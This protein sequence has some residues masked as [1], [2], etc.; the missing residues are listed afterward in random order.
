MT[1]AYV[2]CGNKTSRM[3][4]EFSAN[5]D[6]MHPPIV[7]LTRSPGFTS[8]HHMRQTVLRLTP[9]YIATA[10]VLLTGVAV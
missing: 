3:L 2:F 7:T 1:V 4:P 10:R 8:L 5:D 9:G 6:K